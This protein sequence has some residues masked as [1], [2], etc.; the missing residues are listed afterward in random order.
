MHGP[1]V[2]ELSHIQPY[3]VMFLN[4]MSR[5]YYVVIALLTQGTIICLILPISSKYG[6][7]DTFKR[8]TFGWNILVLGLYGRRTTTNIYIC[9]YISDLL[10]IHLNKD[11][12]MCSINGA[13]SKRIKSISSIT[14]KPLSEFLFSIRKCFILVPFLYSNLT[15]ILK[16]PSS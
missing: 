16:F 4:N 1:C 7:S 14:C 6:C 5:S 2:G 10:H 11:S 15:F 13:S 3:Y 12:F 9:I 8:V